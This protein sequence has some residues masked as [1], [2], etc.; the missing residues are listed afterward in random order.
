[1]LDSVQAWNF[2]FEHGE[3]S[4]SFSFCKGHFQW[5]I[6]KSDGKLLKGTKA[7]PKENGGHGLRGLP[8]VPGVVYNNKALNV[9]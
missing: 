9:L 7:K 8:V 5:K 4:R 1:M 3:S 6:L 2:I